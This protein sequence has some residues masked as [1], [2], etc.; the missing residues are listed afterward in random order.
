M[1]RISPVRFFFV[2]EKGQPVSMRVRELFDASGPINYR[3]G[4]IVGCLRKPPLV[5]ASADDSAIPKSSEER[6]LLPPKDEKIAA[7]ADQSVRPS[8]TTQVA[9]LSDVAIT[10]TDQEVVLPQFAGRTVINAIG[11]KKSQTNQ[12][13][14][15]RHRMGTHGERMGTHSSTDGK[16]GGSHIGTSSAHLAG[17]TS[18]P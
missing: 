4:K 7:G 16:V 10:D 15:K 14:G 9:R 2:D 8:K 18:Q 17:S 3:Y 5:V 6:H 11:A 12:W 13:A 1:S